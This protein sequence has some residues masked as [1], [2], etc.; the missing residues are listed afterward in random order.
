MKHQLFR[1]YEKNQSKKQSLPEIS[2][3]DYLMHPENKSTHKM[4]QPFQQK[5]DY[6]GDTYEKNRNTGD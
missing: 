1:F 5:V 2:Q 3:G 6:E 4:S